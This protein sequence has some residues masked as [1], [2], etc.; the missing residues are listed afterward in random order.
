MGS[1]W[2]SFRHGFCDPHPTCLTIAEIFRL[3]HIFTPKKFSLFFYN[4]WKFDEKS[5][6]EGQVTGKDE[7]RV[8]IVVC[9][10]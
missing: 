8:I 2:F 6:S 1:A 10:W 5:S 3:H 4:S 9:I 7:S